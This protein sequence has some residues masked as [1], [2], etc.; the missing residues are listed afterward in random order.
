MLGAPAGFKAV[1]S[2][3]N[4]HEAMDWRSLGVVT[5]D[6]PDDPGGGN[7]LAKAP[8]IDAKRASSFG[9]EMDMSGS[10]LASPF[11]R[12]ASITFQT[13]RRARPVLC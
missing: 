10:T 1:K 8:Y 6:D 4:N 13:S 7:L 3:E 11:S 12:K 2:Q 5:A 9:L